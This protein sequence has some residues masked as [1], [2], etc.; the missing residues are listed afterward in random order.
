MLVTLKVLRFDC[1][2]FLNTGASVNF[3]IKF[4]VTGLLIIS[5]DKFNLSVLV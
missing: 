3:T 4:Q 1:I 2:R 5:I